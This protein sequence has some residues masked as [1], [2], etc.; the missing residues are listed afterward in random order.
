MSFHLSHLMI[1]SLREALV[2]GP[3][4]LLRHVA[5]LRR[6]DCY[7]TKIKSVGKVRIRSHSSDAKT[8]VQVFRDREYDLSDLR[9]FSRVLAAYNRILS[10]GS[11]PVVI[12]AGANVGAAS[13]W[14][15][16]QFPLARV[17]AIEPDP[18][19]AQL[20]R[21][22]TSKFTNITTLETA[23]GS[24]TGAVSLKHFGEAHWAIQTVRSNGGEVAVRTVSDLMSEIKGPAKL[25]MLKVDIEGFE[26]D[27]FAS[28]TQWLDEVEVV[29]IEPH[30]WLLAGEG[31][32][33]NFQRAISCR[34]FEILVLSKNLAYV[35]LPESGSK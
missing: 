23:I 26:K 19:N 30:D 20:C 35:R 5:G 31:T 24:E 22:N 34:S 3:A 32:S 12:D 28:N 18:A 25:F 29:F 17:L 11:V 14:F 8:F 16:R 27:L 15:A 13:I 9:Q 6:T 10:E 4:F 1:N 7:E 2:L 21:H 33:K